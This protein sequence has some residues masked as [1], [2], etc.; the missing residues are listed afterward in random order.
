MSYHIP[1]LTPCFS[2]PD[3]SIS[4][5]PKATLL[6]LDGF[7]AAPRD[8]CPTC[9]SADEAWE[10]PTDCTGDRRKWLKSQ[11]S[12]VIS[13]ISSE[14][15][16]F[17]L[18]FQQS[19]AGDGTI[20]INS[21]KELSDLKHSLATSILPRLYSRITSANAYLKPATLIVSEM[22]QNL[23]GNWAV[24]FFVTRGGRCIFLAATEQ[25][26]DSANSWLGSRISFLAQDK[27]KQKFT[28][29]MEKIGAWLYSHGYFGPCGADILETDE[30]TDDCSLHSRFKI[31]D[32]NVRSSGSI[33]LG[34]LKGHFSCRRQLHDASSFAMT[35]RMSRESFIKLFEDDVQQGRIIITSWYED[36]RSG[37]SY[38]GVVV[39]A[40]D[41]QALE[42]AVASI[43]SI[44][45]DVHF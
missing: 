19:F 41:K 24:T 26:I 21:R 23:V 15:I 29:L 40:R 6:E 2:S 39:G 4:S 5:S 44:A 34:F 14:P 8:C 9:K 11:V 30:S 17:V 16:P 28:P 3:L 22:V 12:R 20:M 1:N 38:G 45:S 35:M 7:G 18:K 42:T 33:L 10:I 37:V 32:L 31:V 13:Q 43:K 27:L 25:V 36:S